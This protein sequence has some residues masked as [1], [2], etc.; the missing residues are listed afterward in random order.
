MHRKSQYVARAI[1][2]L[3]SDEA[4]FITGVNLPVDGGH[5]TSDPHGGRPST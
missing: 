4:G 2:F 5:A 1:V 3:C